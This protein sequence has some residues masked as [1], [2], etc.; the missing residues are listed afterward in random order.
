[1]LEKYDV[2][3]NRKKLIDNQQK[4]LK[5]KLADTKKLKLMLKMDKIKKEFSYF[6]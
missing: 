2:F 4:Q 3:A 1:M 6:C 5:K